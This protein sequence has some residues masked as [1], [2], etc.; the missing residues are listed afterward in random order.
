MGGNVIRVNR[1][2]VRNGNSS[3][4]DLCT[5][6]QPKVTCLF[7]LVILYASHFINCKSST[8]RIIN[9]HT[10]IIQYL[11]DFRFAIAIQIKIIP[12]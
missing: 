2:E 10:F 9:F 1:I 6:G 8:W 11:D 5:N 12:S 7:A 4:L 3:A